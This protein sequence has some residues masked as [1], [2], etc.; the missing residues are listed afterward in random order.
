MIVNVSSSGALVDAHKPLGEKGQKLHLTFRVNLHKL[1]VLLKTDAVIRSVFTD[2]DGDPAQSAKVH[3]G[4]EFAP[5][6]GND[7]M[8][9]QSLIYQHMVDHPHNVI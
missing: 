7:D 6:D 8:L 9:L 3:H 1:D 2:N 4:I 5:L